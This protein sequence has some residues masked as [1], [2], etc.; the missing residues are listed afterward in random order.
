[1]KSLYLSLRIS[2]VIVILSGLLLCCSCGGSSKGENPSDLNF[3][4][5]NDLVSFSN[6]IVKAIKTNRASTVID[7]YSKDI[8]FD[9]NSLSGIINAY[10][11]AIGKK[12]WDYEAYSFGKAE[13]AGYGYRWIDPY[14][15]TAII[16][17][18]TPTGEQAPFK[19]SK[20]EFASRLD[21]L[22]SFSYPGGEVEK[23]RLLL[24]SRKGEVIK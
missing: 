8:E 11:Q 10:S 3:A 19:I 23:D 24:N 4:G 2:Y 16:I 7:K 13:D 6:L 14:N 9:N 20:L 12:K 22:S 1:M 15:R 21:V 5:A 18:V 17:E